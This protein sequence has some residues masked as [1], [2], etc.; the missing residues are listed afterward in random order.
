MNFIH[1]N[2]EPKQCKIEVYRKDYHHNQFYTYIHIVKEQHFE[3]NTH[4]RYG[5]SLNYRP[6]ILSDEILKRQLLNFR[7]V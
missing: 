4:Q 5:K 2:I 6:S 7:N 3:Q 1:L